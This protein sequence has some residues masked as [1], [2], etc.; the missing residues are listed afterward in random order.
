MPENKVELNIIYR[1]HR[2]KP[3]L[4]FENEKGRVWICNKYRPKFRNIGMSMYSL[5]KPKRPE[6]CIYIIEP[7]CVVE[8]DYRA[9]LVKKFKYVFTWSAKSFEQ[10]IGKEKL[11]EL[12]HPSFL[13]PPSIDTVKQ[14]IIPWEQRK[15]KIIFIAN[16]KTSR[17]SSELYS[18]RIKLANYLNNHTNFVVEWYGNIPLRKPYFKGAIG[19]KH[20]VLKNAKFSV[21][22]ENCY[23]SIFSHN[24]FTEKMPD[25]WFSGAVP[26]YCGCYNVDDFQ[27]GED[28]Y[29]D[30]R[31]FFNG[32]N[33]N[34][35][36]INT[37][38]L[39]KRLK[40]YN[41]DDYEKMTTALLATLNKPDGL[42]HVVSM[43]RAYATMVDTIVKDEAKKA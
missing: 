1:P 3:S 35:V 29:I 18:T 23:H 8:A 32:P 6:D 27:F 31:K 21:C 33:E 42:Y 40:S 17:H 9:E 30:L 2:G 28:A 19:N 16:N 24:Y 34:T 22:I 12:N 37:E 20:D 5:P 15:N 25:V 41:A 4:H 10:K 14:R 26:I 43:P 7:R 38:A 11:I 36:S 13:S 39:V